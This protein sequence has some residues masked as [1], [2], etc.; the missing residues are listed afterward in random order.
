MLIIGAGVSGLL[1]ARRLVDAGR[2]VT[3]VD[4]GRGVGGRLATRR[5]GDGV[6]DHGAQ[7]FTSSDPGFTAEVASWRA[8]GV[9]EQWFD[10]RLEPDGSTVA[11]GHPRWRGTSGMTAIA[12]HLA[13][14]LDLRTGTRVASIHVE[15]AGTGSWRVVIEDGT[16]LLAR[17]LLLT[18]PVPQT[19]E[20]LEA[21]EVAIDP[22]DR[23]TLDSITYH[24]CVAVLA[25]LGGPSGVPEPGALRPAGEPLD[26][27]ADNQR[28]GI[29]P[30][31]AITVH[32]GPDTSRRLWDLPDDEVVAGLLAAVPG[33]QAAPV[34]GGT[35]V[36]RWRYARPETLRDEKFFALRDLPPAVLAGDAFAGARVPGAAASGWAAA[37]ALL[38]LI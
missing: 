27:V 7:F 34:A 1:A 15:G 17:A 10:E 5:I 26:W 9:V 6:F 14:D 2:R 23:I 3:I 28:K 18:A 21:G 31:P 20:L 30:V 24:P 38:D 12:K 19:L 29:S 13:A 16:E 37:E 25:L 35:Q 22:A 32:A 11:D 8:A 4:K 36:Q 33:L